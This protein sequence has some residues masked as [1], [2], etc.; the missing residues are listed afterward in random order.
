MNTAPKVSVIILSW[1]GLDYLKQYL[2][3]VIDTP[4]ANYEVIVADNCSTDNT[5]S[6]IHAEFPTVKCIVHK[7]NLGF[8]EGYNKVIE[9]TDSEYIVLLNQDVDTHG[10]WISPMIQLMEQ[11]PL[12]GAVQPKIRSI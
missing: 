10:D 8:A 1:N 12:L 3:T 11:D 5:V 9:Q 4:Y 7:H 6:Y 2:P